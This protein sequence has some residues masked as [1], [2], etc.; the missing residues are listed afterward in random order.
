MTSF[1]SN[2]VSNRYQINESFVDIH[3]IYNFMISKNDIYY[4]KN[5]LLNKD[6]KNKKAYIITR[7]FRKSLLIFKELHRLS[8]L[9]KKLKFGEYPI[10]NTQKLLILY[11]FK[12]YDKKYIK[13]WIELASKVLYFYPNLIDKNILNPT[14]YDLFKL[15]K[16]ISYDNIICIGW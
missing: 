12:Y 16:K 5:I 7:F 3:N 11:F 14:K 9:D 10:I 2:N 8:M 13:A 4:I 6:D 15:Q 1:I